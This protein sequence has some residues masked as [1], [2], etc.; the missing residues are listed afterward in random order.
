MATRTID[1]EPTGLNALFEFFGMNRTMR[2]DV[3]HP[4]RAMRHLSHPERIDTVSDLV[5]FYDLEVVA[6][7]VTKHLL[8][9]GYDERLL[10]D[11]RSARDFVALRLEAVVLSE[12]LEGVV[13][14][15]RWSR[16]EDA[17]PDLITAGPSLQVECTLMDGFDI[18]GMLNRAFA[19]LDQR[20]PGLGAYVVV[21]GTNE[22]RF[23]PLIEDLTAAPRKKL[24]QWLPRHP[25]VAAFHFLR[26]R[27]LHDTD[28]LSE[29]PDGY[30]LQGTRLSGVTIR[31][32]VAEEPLPAGFE[33]NWI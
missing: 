6:R 7:V 20:R 22:E 31:S 27:S 15:V 16:Y 12:L 30:L 29:I 1:G 11:L 33:N 28:R 21:V 9:R 13:E 25:E 8:G 10:H 14:S 2:L 3:G 4:L 26:P 19:K 23:A 17:T 24:E 5:E 32:K 18:D